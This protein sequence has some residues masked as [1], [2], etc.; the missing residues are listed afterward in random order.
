MNDYK[1]DL[2]E[3]DD[4]LILKNFA[5]A[6]RSA[7]GTALRQF[8]IYHYKNKMTF[9]FDQD[10]AKEYILL[11]YSQKKKWQTINGDYSALRKFYREVKGLAWSIKKLPRPRK[12][13]TLPEIISQQEVQKLIENGVIY[14]HQM[15]MAFF[16]ST[17]LRL[18][19]ALN[20]RLADI[21]GQRKQVRVR[22]GKGAKDRYVQIPECTLNMLRAYFKY[23]RPK[24]YLFN[25]KRKGEKM[26]ST[27]AQRAIRIAKK[28]A[29][30]NK[31]VT[32]HILR[33]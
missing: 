15:L 13:D 20:L 9:P 27:T 3:F 21:D 8:F 18:S 1:S 23:Y 16:Y 17:G 26:S 11:R 30:I 4:Y 10:Q 22:K 6:T 14:K 12:E 24:E 25:G 33:H 5:K 29:K 19:E 32:P 2:K 7:Y 31:K 28:R